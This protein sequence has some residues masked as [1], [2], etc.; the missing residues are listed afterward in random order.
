MNDRR[1]EVFIAGGGVAGIESATG[2]PSLA[3]DLV[4][5]TLAVSPAPESIYKPLTVEELFSPEPATRR[6]LE[7]LVAETGVRSFRRGARHRRRRASPSSMTARPSTS[8]RR[9][10]ARGPAAGAF[11]GE[12]LRTSGEPIDID[13]LLR[14]P[15]STSSGAW[16][17]S[18]RRPEAGRCPGLRAR[19]HGPAP[20][21]RALPRRTDHDRHPRARAAELPGQLASDAVSSLLATRAI[22]VRTSVRAH[23]GADG[24]IMLDPWSERL[25][26]GAAVALPELR[27]PASPASPTSA[28]S[29]RSMS[30]PGCGRPR[31][32]R[33]RRRDQLP[34]QARRARH[35]AGCSGR[36]DRG[37]SG[38]FTGAG[39]SPGDPRKLITG[40]E[41]LTCRPTSRGGGEGVR[42][43][44]PVGQLQKIA[45]KTA[46]LSGRIA[47]SWTALEHGIEVEGLVGR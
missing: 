47:K 16:R 10:S 40:E 36:G 23:E 34:D 3:G 9:S 29:S 21:P 13:A 39:L 33:R 1:T 41:S 14:R 8:T 32:L 35:A 30:T 18:S 25:D 27:G 4:H 17:S 46:Q 44:L 15:P 38:S 24:A 28:A 45:G 2:S 31:R 20:R 22:E 19:A 42:A 5:V 6:E 37:A 11:A 26:A 43:R 12:T 7:P